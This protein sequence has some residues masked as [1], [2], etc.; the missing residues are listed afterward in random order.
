MVDRGLKLLAEEGLGY[1]MLLEKNFD[2]L[3]SNFQEYV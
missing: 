3:D 1:S 2:S